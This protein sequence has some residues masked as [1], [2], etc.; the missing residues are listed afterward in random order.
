MYDELYVK[1]NNGA[2][3]GNQYYRGMQGTS[4]SLISKYFSIEKF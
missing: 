1:C 3:P 2:I 4:V